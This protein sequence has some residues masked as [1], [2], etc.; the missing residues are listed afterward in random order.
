MEEQMKRHWTWLVG[1]CVVLVAAPS[2]AAEVAIKTGAAVALD[3]TRP[4]AHA[5]FEFPLGQEFPTYLAPYVEF[6]SKSGTKTIP[7]GV[8]LLY[9]A[10][11]SEYGG[12]IYFGIGAGFLMVRNGDS[13]NDPLLSA[14]GG[15]AL[16]LTD[17]V[18]VFAQARWFR[19]TS[20]GADNQIGFQVGLEFQVG[21]EF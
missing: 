5:S 15:L 6:Y 2:F 13:D 17:R 20:S 16:G 4:G 18:G 14:G 9:K 19:A 8:A 7:V 10:P 12:T 1:A 11:F 21:E 3:P